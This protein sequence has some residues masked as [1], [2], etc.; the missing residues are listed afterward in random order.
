MFFCLKKLQ[1]NL[2]IFEKKILFFILNFSLFISRLI[3]SFKNKK[4]KQQKFFTKVKFGINLMF[5]TN[6]KF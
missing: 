4:N 3:Q 6:L 1:E 5:K 2:F